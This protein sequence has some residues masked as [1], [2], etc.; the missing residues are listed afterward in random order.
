MKNS[1]CEIPWTPFH[2][3]QVGTR[4]LPAACWTDQVKPVKTDELCVCGYVCVWACVHVWYLG[5]VGLQSQ[6]AKL[7]Q[8]FEAG[9]ILATKTRWGGCVQQRLWM[10]RAG[11]PLGTVIH[12]SVKSICQMCCSFRRGLNYTSRDDNS[13]QLRP[14]LTRLWIPHMPSNWNL[15]Q[16]SWAGIRGIITDRVSKRSRVSVTMIT[17]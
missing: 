7:Q 2:E 13:Q 3:E 5:R 6:T 10:N 15:Q 11:A 14:I 1:S 9:L 17:A 4:T 12:F 8:R 16:Q